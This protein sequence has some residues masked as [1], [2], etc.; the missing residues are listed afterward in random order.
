MC[1]FRDDGQEQDAIFC[2]LGKSFACLSSTGVALKQFV[3]GKALQAKLAGQK[4]CLKQ[5][6]CVITIQH[7]STD[8]IEW[9][10][11]HIEMHI[12]STISLL[13]R[14]WNLEKYRDKKTIDSNLGPNTTI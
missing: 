7:Q 12:Q 11:T 8:E 13:R 6:K 4:A 14:C 5:S 2:L 1:P 9:L 3:A 10:L